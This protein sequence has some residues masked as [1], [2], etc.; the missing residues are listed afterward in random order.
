MSSVDTTAVVKEPE[1]YKVVHTPHNDSE[2]KATES[3][4]IKLIFE[5]MI[6]TGAHPFE[7]PWSQELRNLH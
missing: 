7:W 3:G 2:V 1:F 5:L 4:W 6:E